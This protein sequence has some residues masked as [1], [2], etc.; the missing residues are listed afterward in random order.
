M[1]LYTMTP[2][3][4]T[5]KLIRERLRVS[6]NAKELE[7]QV[8]DKKACCRRAIEDIEIDRRLKTDGLL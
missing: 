2:E 7:R 3:Q 8:L 1:T 5:E 6:D 4:V